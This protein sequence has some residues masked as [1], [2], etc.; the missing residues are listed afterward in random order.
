METLIIA[1]P[2]GEIVVVLSQ[3]PGSTI[4]GIHT[5]WW[6][7]LEYT[8]VQCGFY[9]GYMIKE[10]IELLEPAEPGLEDGE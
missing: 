10:G 4:E 8:D 9:R 2:Q 3:V 6:Y 7:E 1:V 5:G